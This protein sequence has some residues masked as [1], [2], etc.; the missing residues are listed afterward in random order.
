MNICVRSPLPRGVSAGGGISPPAAVLMTVPREGWG[1]PAAYHWG[2]P[3]PL[4]LPG[5]FAL[6][7]GLLLFF[8][9]FSLS[10]LCCSISVAGWGCLKSFKE[11][12]G[13]AGQEQL[14]QEQPQRKK[15]K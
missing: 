7:C 2:H 4:T 8:F 14:G 12:L 15:M 10:Q 3:F 5:I 1:S 13:A 9:L 11:G 6:L